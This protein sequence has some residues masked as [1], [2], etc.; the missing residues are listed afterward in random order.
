MLVFFKPNLALF[1]VPKTGSTSYGLALRGHADIAFAKRTKHMTVGKFHNKVAP[2]LAKTFGVTPERMAIM[3]DPEDHLRS[4]YRYRCRKKL[5]DSPAS[6]IDQSFDEF[7][8]DV[9]GAA[10]SPGARIGSQYKFLSLADGT[11]PVHHL[12]AY[13]D[14][15]QIR[16]FLEERLQAELQI[17]HKNVS[18]PV[19]AP[20]SPEVADR[21][22]AAR[23]EEF[24]LYA[25][26][27]DAGGHLCALDGAG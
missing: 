12:F 1:S 24:A 3:R 14:Q 16:G 20:L 10:P 13:E 18:P 27:C 26:L 2:F 23:A 25:R 5:R 6:T 22:R 21:L 8:L 9:I 19:A 17:G 11:V 4:W 7:V 15:P